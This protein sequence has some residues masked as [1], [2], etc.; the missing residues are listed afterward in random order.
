MAAQMSNFQ[1]LVTLTQ[2]KESAWMGLTGRISEAMLE[3]TVPD[4]RMRSV[5]V[6]GPNGFMQHVRET[7]EGMGFPMEQYQEESFGGAPVLRMT[8]QSVAE[9]LEKTVTGND[10]VAVAIA[11]KDSNHQVSTDGSLSILEVAEQ[12]GIAIRS[13]CRMGACGAC[14]VKTC[15]TKVR[16][17]VTPAALSENDR[18]D[19]HILACVA[20]PIEAVEVH[21]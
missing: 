20:Y 16:Y 10:P 8:K 11:F 7:L 18:A 9:P 21:I 2:A 4:W 15:G 3:L 17:E 14:K 5:Y 6:C 19:G 13:A 12:E 1:L